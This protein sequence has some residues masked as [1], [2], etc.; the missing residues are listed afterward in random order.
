MFHISYHTALLILHRPFARKCSDVTF[1]S[2]VQAMTIAAA[3]VSRLV[4]QFRKRH[5]FADVVPMAVY[6]IFRAAITHLMNATSAQMELR[7]QASHG[8]RTC[9]EALEEASDRFEAQGRRAI[10]A[11]LDLA[12]KWNVMWA[13]PTHLSAA[14]LVAG[15]S[16]TVP[17]PDGA[18]PGYILP[19][20]RFVELIP[21]WY[22]F[23]DEP[24]DS[25]YADATDL[26]QSGNLGAGD[27]DITNMWSYP[28]IFEEP[29]VLDTMSLPSG[30]PDTTWPS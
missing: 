30:G 25:I 14:A 11:I 4:R 16:S 5:S 24:L 17:A 18:D 1:D 13:L 10:G 29:N 20:P 8:L 15:S 26:P 21:D 22:V 23:M 7:K 12:R 28:D 6:H 9:I 27:N 19:R 3:A 2:A